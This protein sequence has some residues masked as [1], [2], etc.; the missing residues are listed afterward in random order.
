MIKNINTQQ[1]SATKGGLMKRLSLM[2]GNLPMAQLAKSQ[3]FFQANAL[4]TYGWL[5]DREKVR[6]SYLNHAFLGIDGQNQIKSAQILFADKA[7]EHCGALCL[8]AKADQPTDHSLAHH[9]VDAHTFD[10][11]AKIDISTDTRQFGQFLEKR[12]CADHLNQKN[13]RI[14]LSRA[15]C[16]R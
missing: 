14:P 4:W 2:D 1:I 5:S 6:F 8:K 3:E 11:H 12:N 10:W 9:C 16:A 13:T 15:I 7:F